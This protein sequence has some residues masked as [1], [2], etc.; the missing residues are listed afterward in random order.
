[1]TSVVWVLIEKV[2]GY[3]DGQAI[4]TLYGIQKST[5]V[6]TKSWHWNLSWATLIHSA[7][8]NLFL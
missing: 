2:I 5:I 6:F 8:L 4:S 1:M 3:L 7:S